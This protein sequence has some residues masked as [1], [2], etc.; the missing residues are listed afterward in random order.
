ME[1]AYEVAAKMVLLDGVTSPLVTIAR[2]FADLDKNVSGVNIK[3]KE[4]GK[5]SAGIA[6]V[7][8]EMSRVVAA[9][10]AAKTQTTMLAGA[11]MAVG[12]SGNTGMRTVAAGAAQVATSLGVATQRAGQLVAIMRTASGG[13]GR[14][15]GGGNFPMLA[16]GWHL[17][18]GPQGPNLIN[19][20]MAQIVGGAAG[21]GGGWNGNIP[22]GPGVIPPGGGV[23]PGA[24]R[25]GRGRGG[26]RGGGGHS[27]GL[28]YGPGG[29]DLGR[30]SMGLG[31]AFVP[32]M[33]AGAAAYVGKEFFDAGAEYQNAF[34]Q[35]KALNLGDRV[36]SQ[37]DALARHKH[38]FGVSQIEM[39]K[40]L[41]EATGLFGAPD[42]AMKYAPQIMALAKANG[43]VLGDHAPDLSGANLMG[44][45]K[46]ID[47]RGGFRSDK[48]FE[49]ELN[50]GEKMLTGSGGRITGAALGQFAQRG[51]TAFR[52][53]SDTGVMNM[54]G[55]LIEL[56]GNAAGVAQMSIYQNLIAGRGSRTAMAA[57]AK[58]GL[59]KLSKVY[60]GELGGKPIYRT[61]LTNVKG[62]NELASDFP[63]WVR[64]VLIPQLASK[65]I[66]GDGAV[67]KAVND[68]L[69]N[70]TGSNLA[71]MI[72]TQLGNIMRDAGLV[73]GAMGASDV[74]KLYGKSA[75][76][77]E[78][79]FTAS[80][81]D[82]KVVFSA[83]VL[84]QVTDML[85]GATHLLE[86]A[87]NH[88]EQIATVVKWLPSSWL[89]DAGYKLNDKFGHGDATDAPAD[90]GKFT[91]RG[92][93]GDWSGSSARKNTTVFPKFAQ[94][95]KNQM[96][97]ANLWVGP[98]KILQ[99]VVRAIPMASPATSGGNGIDHGSLYP[100]A[101]GHN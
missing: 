26:N 93:T 29:I 41:G 63:G 23:P 96:V 31:D 22:P 11:L 71:T 57:A 32:V 14:I 100:G 67:A 27:G 88:S 82:F 5:S 54:A 80:W 73:K 25:G 49:R 9:A 78:D 20:G 60:E 76:G 30:A 87:T 7:A 95:A 51:G 74:T 89:V 81:K 72:A 47:M 61:Q 37:A 85:H 19:M 21:G 38:V 2:H 36:N 1:A 70:R 62:A 50:L 55:A 75:Q 40:G 48:D 16:G 53:L 59:G 10:A 56:G 43:A 18:G 3:L 65:G 8:A 24:G 17:G 92:A 12:A 45:L 68:M 42:E 98:D 39:M 34:M 79:D 52:A 44:L 64:D 91:G 69:G 33:I 15:G 66:T 97:Q 77:A 84:P 58:F 94:D 90:G 86:W 13:G 6:S 28:H 99:A 4:T 83:K 101:V 35:F 46:F